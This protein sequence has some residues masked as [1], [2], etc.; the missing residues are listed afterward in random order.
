MTSSRPRL[1][2]A[3][4]CLLA[5]FVSVHP[6]RAQAPGDEAATAHRFQRLRHDPPALRL[7]LRAFPKGADLHNHLAGAVYAESMLRWAVAD[8]LCIERTT[9]ILLAAGC[10]GR[11]DEER[12]ASFEGRPGD[13]DAA[14]DAFSMRD[15]VPTATD[16]SGHDH[17]FNS[18][19]RFILAQRR[20]EADALAEAATRA[21]EDGVVYLELMISPQLAAAAKAGL[22]HPVAGKAFAA[23]DTALAPSLAPLVA[24]ARGETDAMEA[25]MRERLHCA[26]KAA[27]PGCS[28][29][30]R[31]LYAVLRTLPPDAV[32]GQLAMGYAMAGAD[33]RFVGVNIVAPED[34]PVA[35]RDY[36]LHMRMFRALSHRHPGVHLALHAGELTEGLVPPE[37]LRRHIRDAVEI[38]GAE[39]IGHGVDI[40]YEDDAAGLMGEMARRGVMVEINLT[41]N[42]EI[43][44]VRGAQ[45]PLMT[46]RAAGVPTA[47]ST[48]DEGVS[49][50][51]LTHEYERAVADYPLTYADL[52]DLS[53]TG[54]E[55]GFLPGR[56]LWA[57]VHPWRMVAA[58]APGGGARSKPCADLLAASDKARLQWTLEQRFAV[59]EH[60]QAALAR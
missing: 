13:W 28:V 27:R 30:I 45:H 38:A 32:F 17:F 7:F 39:R 5:A 53:R 44:G 14:V 15:F 22:A 18:F 58:C 52:K 19:G 24:A 48:D 59:F 20:H 55:H 6:A 43:L 25:G 33:P 26:T 46:Y 41:S 29:T 42:D 35:L 36:D 60:E 40:T 10:A 4:L 34:N 31:Y 23:A 1:R 47:L 37:D 57:S 8:D 54:L 49:R 12:A 21:A 2:V 16:R 3:L 51:D 11:T 56:S 9:L 50:I